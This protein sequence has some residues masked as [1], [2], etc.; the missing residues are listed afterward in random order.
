MNRKFDESCNG[1]V[2][3]VFERSLWRPRYAY[4][5][6]ACSIVLSRIHGRA[7]LWRAATASLRKSCLT[8]C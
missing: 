3:K 8:I 2:V 1:D 4:W 7:V 5:S 6:S